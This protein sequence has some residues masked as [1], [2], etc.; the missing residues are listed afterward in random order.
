MDPALVRLYLTTFLFS[1]LMGIGLPLVPQHLGLTFHASLG[2][3]GVVMG[4]HGLMQMVLRLPLGDMADRRGRKLSLLLSFLLTAAAG[5]FYAAA[6]SARWIVPGHMLFGL[7]SG[8]YWVAANSYLF[9][10]VTPEQVPRATSDYALSLGA[11]LLIGPPLAGWVADAWGFR[12]ALGLFIWVSLAG[13]ALVA[14]L[15]EVRPDPSRARPPG[16]VV[17]RAARI[18]RHPDIAVSAAGT[19]LFS[20]LFGTL[21]AFFPVYLRALS[22]TALVVGVLF[23]LRQGAGLAVR[24]RLPAAIER[25][26]PRAVLVAGILVASAATALL[27]L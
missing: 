14:T 23:A 20:L 12:A 10:R 5:V 8:I 16:G 22:Y 26:G 17:R 15:P 13:L 3:I 25:F 4:L 9:D 21:A 24:V 11:A 6:P 2:F 27:P 7:A 19:F 18:L 1:L